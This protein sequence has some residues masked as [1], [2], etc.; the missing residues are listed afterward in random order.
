MS[1]LPPSTGPELTPYG[2]SAPGYSAP[3]QYDDYSTMVRQRAAQKLQDIRQGVSGDEPVPFPVGR[4]IGAAAIVALPAFMFLS[5]AWMGLTEDEPMFAMFFLPLGLAALSI[6]VVMGF[7]ARTSKPTGALRAYFK[8][9]GKGRHK[10]ARKLVTQSD[11]DALQ[12]R[13]PLI[14]KLGRPSGMPL[15][16]DTEQVFARYWNEL[17]RTRSA[18]YCIVRVS[19]VEETPL[20]ADVVLVK[21]RIR[22]IMNSSLWYLLILLAWPVAIIAD[23][24]TRKTVHADLTKVMVRVGDQWKLFNGE[25]QGYDELDLSWLDQPAEP[26]GQHQTPYRPSGR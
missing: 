11:L 12:R 14:D 8:A 10:Y 26:R 2:H 3:V 22:L 9:L 4:I 20:A 16:F 7:N 5:I 6:P 24:A 19:G 15:S 13:Q 23:L 25:W 17:L 1:N 21:C 18:P